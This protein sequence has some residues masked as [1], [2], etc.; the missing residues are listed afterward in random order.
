MGLSSSLS[1]IQG[2]FRIAKENPLLWYSLLL[3]AGTVTA[4]WYWPAPVTDSNPSDFRIR[5]WGMVLQLIGAYTVWHDLTESARK[6]GKTSLLA[7]TIEWAKRL[8]FG[9]GHALGGVCATTDNVCFGGR[10]TS[11][12]PQPP[13]GSPLESRIETLEYN[14]SKVDEELSQALR[15]IT[16]TKT[17]LKEQI[18]EE[19]K[20]REEAHKEIQKDLHEA[21][22]GNY[23][24]LVF[25]AFWVAIGILVSALAPEIAKAVA[26]QWALISRTI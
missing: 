21:I 4:I 26:G 11:R 6:F 18:K 20:K 17:K 19:S 25:G 13:D 9:H 24:T 16:D 2:R 3:A 1:I 10:A 14:L 5:L 7:N 12:R 15:Q 22:V 23:A 8:I